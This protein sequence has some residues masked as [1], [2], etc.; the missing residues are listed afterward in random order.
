MSIL[1]RKKIQ[2]VVEVVSCMVS[3]INDLEYGQKLS[4]SAMAKELERKEGGTHSWTIRNK[5]TEGFLWKDSLKD[6]EP[7]K[8]EEG[9][10]IGIRKVEPREVSTERILDI[11][12]K[13]KDEQILIKKEI[14]QLK[15]H[16]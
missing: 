5:L 16:S 12:I 6:C 7:E 15:H 13:I 1:K 2:K 3:R 10:V 8:N 11:L 4:M 14:E 9:W